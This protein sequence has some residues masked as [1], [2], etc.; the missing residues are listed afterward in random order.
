MRFKKTLATIG[1]VGLLA[2]SGCEQ[3]KIAQVT[4]VEY[5]GASQGNEVVI[6][7]EYLYKT[8][9]QM[10]GNMRS[11]PE[12]ALTCRI[13]SKDPH[14]PWSEIIGIAEGPNYEWKDIN[15]TAREKMHNLPPSIRLQ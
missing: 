11:W 13:Y 1:L 12:Y 6:D 14:S 10:G 4:H 5:K 15:F 3:K 9:G 7:Q 8:I 2:I